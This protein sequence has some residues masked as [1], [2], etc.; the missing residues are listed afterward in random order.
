MNR[1]GKCV[2]QYKPDI[3]RLCKEVDLRNG[4]VVG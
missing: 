2:N 4:Q 1:L 3:S